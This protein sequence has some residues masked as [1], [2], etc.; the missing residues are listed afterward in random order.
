VIE[1]RLQG[2]RYGTVSRV[3]ASVVL[4]DGDGTTIVEYAS[5]PVP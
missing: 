4:A 1:A 3:N 5:R 2:E